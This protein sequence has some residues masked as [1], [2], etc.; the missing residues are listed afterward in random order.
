MNYQTLVFDFD[1]TIADT[2]GE[3]RLIF[4]RIAPD[5]GIRQVAEHELDRTPPPL[6]QGFARPPQDP[7]APRPVAHLPRHL[8]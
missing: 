7:E 5:Y 8:A 6:A 2:L 3:T 1:G 4:N